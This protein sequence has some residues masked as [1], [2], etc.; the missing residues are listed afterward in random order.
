MTTLTIKASFAISA[1]ASMSSWIGL[2]SRTPVRAKGLSMKREQWLPSTVTWSATPGSTLLRPPEKPAKKCGS[3][4]PSATSSSVS[5]ARR[6]I[7]QGAP[8]GSVPISTLEEASRQSCTTMRQLSMISRPSLSSSSF[9][10]V[11]RWKPVATRSVTSISGLP[12]RSSASMAGRI[13]RLGTGRVWSEMMMTQ[14]F[15]PRASSRR[16]GLSTGLSIAARTISPPLPSAFSSPMREVS[17][18]APPSSYSIKLLPYGMRIIYALAF[19]CAIIASQTSSMS[20]TM[21]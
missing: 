17:T 14:F 16:R 4:K 11:G 2:R 21:P 12:S 6:S 15:F 10:L 19:S 3:M 13:S 5:T 7:T 9:V 8:E 18:G 20:P 1:A